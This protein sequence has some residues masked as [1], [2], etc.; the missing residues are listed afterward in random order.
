MKLEL[1]KETLKEIVGNLRAS[2]SK[3]GINPIYEHFL[4]E[5]KD[6][7]LTI[8]ATDTKTATLFNCPVDN[9]EE[10]SFTLHGNTL[11]SLLTTLDEDTIILEYDLATSDVKL[12]C[13]KYKLDSASGNVMEYPNVVVPNSKYLKTIKLPENFSVMLKSVSFSI[14]EDISKKD[15]NSLCMDINKDKSGNLSLVSTDRIRL[16]YATAPIENTEEY[17][18][19]I[20][21]RNSVSEIEKFEPTELMYGPDKQRIYLVKTTSSGTYI[22]QTVL[23]NVVYPDIY[24]YLTEDFDDCKVINMNRKDVLR[25][26]KRI[27]LTSDRMNKSGNVA[28]NDGLMT[29]SSLSASN[30]S[31][32]DVE[33]E[34][35]KGTPNPFSINLDFVM[36]YLSQETEETVGI[37]VI[38]NS[39][40]VFDKKD[41][42][43]VL[44]VN[45]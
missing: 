17:L 18:R 35:P 20:I 42:R 2:L 36:D 15:L 40:L 26:L 7:K 37:K 25:V 39:C 11:C 22:F 16:S 9:P 41:Y 30:K 27:R 21:P 44:A 43:H 28:F 4:F 12:V 8:K 31:K 14:G 33:I 13:G 5:V 24:T 10:F 19:F 32:E 23:S 34:A 1:S 29:L 3:G 45:S 38:E 6:K